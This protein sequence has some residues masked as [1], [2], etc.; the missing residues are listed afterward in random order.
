MVGNRIKRYKILDEIGTG[1]IATVYRARDSRTGSIVAVK[2]MHPHLAKDQVYVQRFRREAQTAFSLYDPHIVKVLDLGEDKG[3][4]F[5]VMEY[6]RDETLQKLIQDRH[7]LTVEQALDIAR[8][9]TRTL[10]AA[11]RQGIVHRDIKPQNLMVTPEGLVKAMDFGI[12]K[13]VDLNTITQTG[14]F[15]GSPHYMSPQQAKGARGNDI[16]SD[17]YSLGVVLH[18]MLTGTV[19]FD[20]DSPWAVLHKQVEGEPVPV[21]QLR[22]DVPNE[23]GAVVQTAVARDPQGRKRC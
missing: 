14:A 20:G 8:Q 7:S 11:H 22:V 10:D 13:A 17:I 18:Q 6:V 3:N 1:G 21:H 19:P 16:R 9:V 23:V 2:V 5:L 12:A 15:I 4:Y